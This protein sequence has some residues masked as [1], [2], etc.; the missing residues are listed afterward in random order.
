MTDFNG[1]R[2]LATFEG[3]NNNTDKGDF[4]LSG[5]YS[6]KR[7]ENKIFGRWQSKIVKQRYKKIFT[8]SLA[9]DP[10]CVV[11]SEHS[12]LLLQKW[13]KETVEKNL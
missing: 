9:V 6:V 8:W 7:L 1:I 10:S 4:V 13:I 12:I 11:N 2:F 3:A 5:W